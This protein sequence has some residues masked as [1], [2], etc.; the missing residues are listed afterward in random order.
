MTVG[1]PK[2]PFAFGAEQFDSILFGQYDRQVIFYAIS[3]RVRQAGFV[4]Y[5]ID[6]I[7]Y[8][9]FGS[10][11]PSSQDKRPEPIIGSEITL[12]AAKDLG[13]ALGQCCFAGFK[14]V[15]AAHNPEALSIHIDGISNLKA[16]GLA[17]FACLPIL[18]V[19]HFED[20]GT[21][22]GFAKSD[23]EREFCV[24]RIV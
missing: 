4:I 18:F 22:G 3:H 11:P 2:Q 9:R 21:L 19:H 14:R 10:G 7:R 12:N 1:K 8:I 23:L 16:V 20:T 13:L 15:G 6:G 5:L 17:L 24:H